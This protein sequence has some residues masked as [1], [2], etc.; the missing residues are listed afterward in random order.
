MSPIH[1]PMTV[2]T[3]SSD[4][5]EVL[6]TVFVVWYFKSSTPQPLSFHKQILLLL[7]TLLPR[8]G[9][10][11]NQ[12]HLS[13]VKFLLALPTLTQLIEA[14]QTGNCGFVCSNGGSVGD[15]VWTELTDQGSIPPLSTYV[16]TACSPT[17]KS[18]VWANSFYSWNHFNSLYSKSLAE[19]DQSKL[20]SCSQSALILLLQELV[21]VLSS[22]LPDPG[23]CFSGHTELAP[24]LTSS[25]APCPTGLPDSYQLVSNSYH[26]A[27]P[28]TLLL[29]L[30]L[31]YESWAIP[32]K[33]VYKIATICLQNTRLMQEI[34][35]YPQ[36][37][38]DQITI[39]K[40]IAPTF[41]FCH[42]Q[43]QHSVHI[44]ATTLHMQP[45][46]LRATSHNQWYP[47]TTR[48]ICL[49]YRLRTEPQHESQ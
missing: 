34:L 13:H 26:N 43:H 24:R 19:L 30:T 49:V 15:V 18:N 23:N 10:N 20:N 47:H 12:L 21:Q 39:S 11:C 45:P 46:Q 14:L 8:R 9:W 4:T 42:A 7:K 17:G 6:W 36:H 1:T 16:Y 2:Y 5:W 31:S 28:W 35:S 32:Q 48:Q 44:S 27:S 29:Y 25:S 3:T 33:C 38:Q 37:T 41:K 22:S 40:Y